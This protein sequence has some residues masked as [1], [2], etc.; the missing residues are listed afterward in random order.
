[1]DSDG[2]VGGGPPPSSVD[3]EYPEE[4][5]EEEEYPEE[6]EDEY[7][8]ELEEPIQEEPPIQEP[9]EEP[10]QMLPSVIVECVTFDDG[11]KQ[12]KVYDA[13][14]TLGIAVGVY[15]NGVLQD[16]T[17]AIQSRGSTVIFGET[18]P[19]IIGGSRDILARKR[20]D[21]QAYQFS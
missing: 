21:Y 3:G 4:E 1:M 5:E 12:Q 10:L 20:N 6:E 2:S 11:E 19:L 9:K 7:P 14:T 13:E 18:I 8:E 17:R 15:V 16:R